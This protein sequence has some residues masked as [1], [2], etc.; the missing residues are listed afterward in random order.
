MV[1]LGGISSL[2]LGERGTRQLRLERHHLVGG[3][4]GRSRLLSEQLEHLDDVL[5][6]SV[7]DRFGLGVVL[8]V[9]VAVGKPEAVLIN[10]ADHQ[11][12]VLQVLGR[13]ERE[14]R[15]NAAQVKPPDRLG[16]G[17][18]ALPRE[19][20]LV[21]L[22]LHLG[23]HLLELRLVHAAGVVISQLLGVRGA[24]GQLACGRLLEHLFEDQLIAVADR[25]EPPRVPLAIGWNR[26]RL[27][28]TAAGIAVEI[29]ARVDAQ[30]HRRL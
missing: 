10:L 16:Q 29:L 19:R 4:L 7:A 23:H 18:R 9:V 5:G 21:E 11:R 15:S 20:Q 26:G 14:E 25:G 24:L 28:P 13:V 30:I 2:D 8:H 27:E 3:L 12:R 1:H 17:L 22:A 6:V